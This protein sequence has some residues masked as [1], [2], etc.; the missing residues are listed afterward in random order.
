VQLLF[1]KRYN[2][3]AT[4]QSPPAVKSPANPVTVALP[5]GGI[6]D[7]LSGNAAKVIHWL[8]WAMVKVCKLLLACGSHHLH[9]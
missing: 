6:T 7:D 1:D 4:L 8:A 2:V 3:P 5:N 9:M